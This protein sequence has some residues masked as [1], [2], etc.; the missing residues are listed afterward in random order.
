MGTGER[1][2][3]GWSERSGRPFFHVLSQSGQLFFT[4]LELLDFPAKWLFIEH[5]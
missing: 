3:K 2:H 5:N 1:R 4:F